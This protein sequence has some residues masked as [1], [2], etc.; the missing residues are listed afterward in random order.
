MDGAP[1]HRGMGPRWVEN[2]LTGAGLRAAAALNIYQ[3]AN[4][5]AL[6]GCTAIPQRAVRERPG[7]SWD[8][9]LWGSHE[10]NGRRVIDASECR[11]D[12]SGSSQRGKAVAVPGICPTA[13]WLSRPGGPQLRQRRPKPQR[14][15]RGPGPN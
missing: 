7:Q 15:E 10:G 14:A 13:I 12:S 6:T 8:A 1:S 11:G 3:H 2:F 9:A 5:G 4:A